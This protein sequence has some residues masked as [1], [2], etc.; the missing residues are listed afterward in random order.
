MKLMKKNKTNLFRKLSILLC[1]TVFFTSCS[2]ENDT[3]K[4]EIAFK[5]IAT[6]FIE[7]SKGMVINHKKINANYEAFMNSLTIVQGKSYDENGTY[8]FEEL[9]VLFETNFDIP[10]ENT[11]K[12][13]NIAYENRDLLLK[14]NAREL[15]IEQ[16]RLR[17]GEI[18]TQDDPNEK[19]LFATLFGMLAGEDTHCSLLVLAHIADAMVLTATAAIT[20]PTGIGAVV[21]GTGVASSVA[22]ASYEASNCN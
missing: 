15:L 5:G 18:I 16:L 3:L 6:Q 13:F 17:I 20:A 19:W 1:F 9:S 21:A 11:M 12:F 10:R 2:E 4:E 7:N 14:E 8:T 22:A